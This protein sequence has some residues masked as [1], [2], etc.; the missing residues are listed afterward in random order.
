[1][2]ELEGRCDKREAC[3]KI[4]VGGELSEFTSQKGGGGRGTTS[5]RVGGFLEWKIN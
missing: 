4:K 1:M 2:L 3:L 5:L